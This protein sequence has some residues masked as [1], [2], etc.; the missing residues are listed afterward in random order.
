M[1]KTCQEKYVPRLPYRRVSVNILEFWGI[2]YLVPTDA[3][4]KWLDI[5]PMKGK[6]AKHVI[7]ACRTVFAV[8]GNPQ[9]LVSDN[10]PF[11]S[12]EFLRF[13]RNKFQCNFSS[14]KFAQSNELAEKGT[15]IAKQLLLKCNETQTD[16][17]D[18]L[19]AY[20]NMP[21]PGLRASPSQ[22]FFSQSVRTACPIT[23]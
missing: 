8:H 17:R 19:Y 3:Y 23:V 22:L 12:I 7:E 15:H 5:V 6:T 21:I 2:S 9:I 13:A 1:R 20:R 18:E 16:Y 14:L 10:V 4:S 11:N